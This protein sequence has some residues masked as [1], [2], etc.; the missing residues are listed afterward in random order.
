MIKGRDLRRS[1]VNWLL[2]AIVIYI[3]Y[4]AVWVADVFRLFDV[5]PII[6]NWK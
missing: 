5:R 1:D 3:L 6:H 4:F 2:V